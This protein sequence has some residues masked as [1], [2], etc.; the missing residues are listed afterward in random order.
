MPTLIAL[1]SWLGKLRSSFWRP[2]PAGPFRWLLRLPADPSV[3][4]VLGEAKVEA[5]S[6][7]IENHIMVKRRQRRC[8]NQRPHRDTAAYLRSHFCPHPFTT[9]E[10]TH[11]GLAFVCCPVWL[12]T[13][14]GRLES[15]PFDLWAGPKA[16][17]IRASI[18]DGSFRYCD[19][20]NCSRITNRTLPH[21]DSAEARAILE[22]YEAG[23]PRQRLP[24]Y[25]TLSHDKSCNLSCPSCRARLY[26]AGK[27]KQAELDHVTETS[28]LPLLRGAECVKITGSGDPFGSNH[29][30]NLIKRLH[31]P[32]FSRVKIDLHTNG[33]LWDE[34]AWKELELQGRVRHAHVSID[35]ACADTYAILRRGGR[36]DRLLENLAF[37]RALR[38]SGEIEELEFSMVVQAGNFREM[39]DF[40]RLGRAFAADTISFQMIRKR[41][42]FSGDEFEAAFIGNPAHRDHREFLEVLRAPELSLPGVQI[43]NVMAYVQDP[44]PVAPWS[45][46][47]DR[48][49]R[50]AGGVPR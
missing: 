19:H 7:F 27:A 41:D 11:T 15:D 35:A 22:D 28:I 32:D 26:V 40:V 18:I 17:E 6:R 3:H 50:R 38:Q 16:R 14:I 9:L 24:K 25:V 4:A 45:R 8:R 36:F 23:S 37:I 12:P 42:I 49:P 5:V 34:R 48:I 2:G 30:R 44:R 21:R 47:A 43:G 10:T 46:R 20:L 31:A 33:Q 39:P 13:P 1:P 29:F